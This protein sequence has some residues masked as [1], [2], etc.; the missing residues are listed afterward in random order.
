[1]KRIFIMMFAAFAAACADHSIP[2]AQYPELDRSNPLLAEWDTPHQTPPFSKI[3]P[4]HFEPAVD[5]AIACSRAEIEAIVNNPAKP[6]FGNTILALERQGELLNRVTGVFYNLM[7]TE[8]TPELQAIAQRN[9]P[10]LL[11]A[12]P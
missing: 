3:K 12:L 9:Q 6:S 5:A 4:E 7:G 8:S 11:R 1:M 2:A 10:K